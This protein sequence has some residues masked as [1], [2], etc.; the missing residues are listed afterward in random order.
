MTAEYRK[1]FKRTAIGAILYLGVIAAA[2]IAFPAKAQN[3]WRAVPQGKVYEDRLL[4]STQGAAR[5]ECG[6]GRIKWM[7]VAFRH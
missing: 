2:C 3:P 5:T 4:R 6:N 7:K 1:H